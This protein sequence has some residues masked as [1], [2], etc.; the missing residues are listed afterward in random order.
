MADIPHYEYAESAALIRVRFFQHQIN[1]MLKAGKFRQIPIHLAFG[2][3]AAAVGMALTMQATD[4][5]CLS[6]RN[7]A[8]NLARTQSL[9]D[10][11]K[12]YRMESFRGVGKQ[13]ASMNLACPDTGIAYT[14]SILGNNLA[15]SAGIA[16][17]RKLTEREGIVFVV[18]G[19]GAME[20][21]IFWET[22]IFARS[23]RLGLVIVVEN[24]NCSM[25]STIEQRRFPIDL[26]MVCRGL[27]VEYRQVDGASLPL[28][29]AALSDARQDAFKGKVALVE[30]QIATFCQHA[31]PTP[32]WPNDPLC[33]TLDDGLLIG[34]DSRDPLVQ[35]SKAIGARKFDEI[36]GKVINEGG[37]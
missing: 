15:V 19:D 14:S 34:D 11:V 7:A 32:G 33:I 35:L 3:E 9:E 2:H 23:H 18:T 6:H 20:E 1:E 27:D 16:M 37:Q 8:Y 25:S 12:Y 4:A 28:V 36:A 5:L 30:L 26:S 24:N 10:V 29:K 22:L 13:M 31:G 21:G 17:N